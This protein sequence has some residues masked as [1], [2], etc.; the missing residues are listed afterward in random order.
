MRVTS[1]E[2]MD[3]VKMVLKGQ[4][5]TSIVSLINHNGGRARGPQRP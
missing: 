5:N 3:V 1:P 4:V 2:V